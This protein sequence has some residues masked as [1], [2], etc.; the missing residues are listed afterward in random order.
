MIEIGFA[1]A[2][3]EDGHQLARWAARYAARNKYLYKL[4]E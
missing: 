4:E 1:T 2:N 3:P